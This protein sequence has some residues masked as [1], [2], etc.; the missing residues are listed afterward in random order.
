MALHL[1]RSRPTF[2]EHNPGADRA[3]EVRDLWL[4][5]ARLAS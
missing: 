4:E 1:M 3:T 2:L 5:Y